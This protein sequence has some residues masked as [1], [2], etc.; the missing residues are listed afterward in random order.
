[1]KSTLIAIAIVFLSLIYVWAIRDSA[2]WHP[3]IP[4]YNSSIP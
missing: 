2:G 1:M 3:E 4:E